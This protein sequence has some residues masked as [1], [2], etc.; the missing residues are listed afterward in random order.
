MRTKRFLC[1]VT[2]F[3]LVSWAPVVSSRS[4]PQQVPECDC[5][6]TFSNFPITIA[7]E[8]GLTESLSCV[9][10][11]PV[12]NCTVTGNIPWTPIS[13]CCA[14]S[15]NWSNSNVNS[16]STDGPCS[17]GAFQQFTNCSGAT[18]NPHPCQVACEDAPG[19]PHNWWGVVID[20][21][22]SALG[23]ALK[24]FTCVYR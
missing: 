1:V 18:T 20:C 22:G 14:M 7:G 13:N 4:N 12:H 23:S 15:G 3:V 2:L 10:N 5:N 9:G 16:G 8:G 11:S 21:S 24:Q 17:M 19:T 6:T